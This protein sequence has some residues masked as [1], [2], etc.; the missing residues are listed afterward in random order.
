M[1]SSAMQGILATVF[2]ASF[3]LADEAAV[4][5]KT[6]DGDEV[7]VASTELERAY[8]S[9]RLAGRLKSNAAVSHLNDDGSV[10]I[11]FPF[12]RVGGK[13]HRMYAVNSEELDSMCQ[14]FG[15]KVGVDFKR[16]RHMDSQG[17]V[18]YFKEG[19][20]DHLS[21]SESHMSEIICR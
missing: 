18:A 3:A 21:G 10:S 5:L 14:F 7:Q 6:V 19:R 8:V 17:P 11:M 9:F 15:L 2:V 13:E 1:F 20:L 16:E 12:I 4:R